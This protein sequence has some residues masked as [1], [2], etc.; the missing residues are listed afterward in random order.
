MP[1][2]T[3][4]L[5]IFYKKTQARFMPTAVGAPLVIYI[6]GKIGKIFEVW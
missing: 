1:L 3:I 5:G 6:G 2:G 4:R